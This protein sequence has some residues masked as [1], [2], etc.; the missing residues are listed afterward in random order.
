MKALIVS[1]WKRRGCRCIFW[2]AIVLG[3]AFVHPFPRQLFFG[4]KFKGWPLCVW[5]SRIRDRVDP[6][7]RQANWFQ[8]ALA[9]VGAGQAVRVDQFDDSAE[10]LPLYLHL[11]E[12]RD[13]RVRRLML[14]WLR[15]WREPEVVALYRRHLQDDNVDCRL[16]AACGL[17]ATGEDRETKAVL[18]PLP[19]NCET[20]TRWMVVEALSGMAASNPDLFEPLAKLIEDG[21]SSVREIAVCSMPHFG[22]RGVAVL[23]AVMI[24]KGDD[25]RCHAIVAT[26]YLGKDA[27][28]LIPVLEAIRNDPRDAMCYNAQETLNKIDPERFPWPRKM[29]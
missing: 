28:E 7:R 12:D 27:A 19:D 4:P 21:D 24:G 26:R 13:P 22:K 9:F 25:I 23:R 15:G 14:V 17:W 10:L 6:E 18:L 20:Q 2:V 29:K 11:A 1:F 8:K 3:L 16:L 5:E